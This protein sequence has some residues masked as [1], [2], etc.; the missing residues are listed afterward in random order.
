MHPICVQGSIFKMSNASPEIYCIPISNTLTAS[1]MNT[2]PFNMSMKTFLFQHIYLYALYVPWLSIH[3][4]A[5]CLQFLYGELVLGLEVPVYLDESCQ[6]SGVLD[7]VEDWVCSSISGL[8]VISSHS[9]RL[10]IILQ[11]SEQTLTHLPLGDLNE[12]F[13]YE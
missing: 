1:S 4:C 11:P 13:N 9:F 5:G 3:A 7:D 12:I 8:G 2:F 6:G 10:I